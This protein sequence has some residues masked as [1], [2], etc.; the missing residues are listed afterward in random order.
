M[1]LEEYKTLCHTC[2]SSTTIST[3][4]TKIVQKYLIPQAFVSILDPSE[5]GQPLGVEISALQQRAI[6]KAYFEHIEKHVLDSIAPILEDFRASKS[7]SRVSIQEVL[8]YPRASAV[9]WMFCYQH[10]KEREEVHR[11]ISAW[12][13]LEYHIKPMC[14]HE[15]VM[16]TRRRSQRIL[17]MDTWMA[18]YVSPSDQALS[19]LLNKPNKQDTA[20][21]PVHADNKYPLE[22]DAMSTC[23]ALQHMLIERLGASLFFEKFC[24]P[25]HRRYDDL[26]DHPTWNMQQRERRRSTRDSRYWNVFRNFRS[27]RFINALQQIVGRDVPKPTSRR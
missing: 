6:D 20:L 12:M 4:A 22:L 27:M 17:L 16:D 3:Y 1:T 5:D 25:V 8:G 19:A 2:A 11:W 13:E 18:K 15:T 9:F 26:I 7:S 23:N 14:T 10:S 21:S 24:S